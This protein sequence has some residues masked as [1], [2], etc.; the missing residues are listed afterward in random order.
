MKQRTVRLGGVRYRVRWVARLGK[1]PHTKHDKAGD[2]DVAAREIRIV[3]GLDE[4]EERRVLIHEALHACLPMLDE[5]AV[6]KASEE[7]NEMLTRC[8]FH[9]VRS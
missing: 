7:V 3:G 5:E 2:C 9:P 6:D 4:H 8:G 1:V